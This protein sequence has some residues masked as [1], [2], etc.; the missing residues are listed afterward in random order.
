MFHHRQQHSSGGFGVGLGVVVVKLRKGSV[1]SLLTGS[2]LLSSLPALPAEQARQMRLA[3][4]FQ[5]L[6]D[7]P[8]SHPAFPPQTQGDSYGSASGD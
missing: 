7:P 6:P 3:S 5:P 4:H 1:H 2:P 8:G